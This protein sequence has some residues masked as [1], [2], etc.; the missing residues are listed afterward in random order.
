[1]STWLWGLLLAGATIVLAVTGAMVTRHRI[2]PERL[3]LNNEVAGFIYAVIGVVY[4]V[5][6]GFSALIVWEQYDKAQVVV[7]EEA[8]KLAD[9]YRSAQTFP[10][11]MRTEVETSLRTYARLVIDKEWPA[12]AEGQFS[13]ETWDAY[14]HL[15]RIY[16]NFEPSNDHERTWFGESL[17][18]MND[19]GDQRRLRLLASRSEAV[20]NVMWIVLLGAGAVTVSFTLLF[21]TMNPTAHILMIAALATTIALVL[22]SIFAMHEPFAGVTRVEPEAFHQV[23]EL[24]DRQSRPDGAQTSAPSGG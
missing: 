22:F 19:L 17:T 3:K 13:P 21:G 7:E 10:D 1:M 9:L 14:D 11:D 2:G 20:P 23:L 4:A 12:M 24:F 18:R 5:L 6:L 8:N 15:W 16:Q